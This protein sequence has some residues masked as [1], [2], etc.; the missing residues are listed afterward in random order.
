LFAF[1]GGAVRASASEIGTLDSAT[2]VI[3]A[4]SEIPLRGI[5]PV[6]MQDAKAVII[7]PNVVKAGLVVGGRHGHGVALVREPDGGWSYPLFVSLSG[8][9]V[10]WQ[11]GV[12]STDVVLIFKNKSALDRLLKGKGKLTLGADIAVAAGPVGRQAEAGTDGQFKA[13]IYS[14]SRSRG[15]FAGVSLEGAVLLN[16]SKGNEELANVLAGRSADV[17]ATAV[18]SAADRLRLELVRLSGVP[19]APPPVIVPGPVAPVP[20]P[21]IYPVPVPPPPPNSAGPV[22]PPPP[23]V[24]GRY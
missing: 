10:G 20:A 3:T 16:D 5:P 14:Y 13:E 2:E 12:Q 17:R 9:S 21:P 23:P 24:P 15:L 11:V 7:V 4:L 22:P 8:G 1:V 19:V 18:L 6:L